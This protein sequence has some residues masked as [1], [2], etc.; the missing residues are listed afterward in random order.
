MKEFNKM[1]YGRYN[2]NTLPEI[3]FKDPN[4][5]FDE[6]ES[7]SFRIESDELQKEA[8]DIFILAKSINIPN[9][10]YQIQEVVYLFLPSN[11]RLAFI[12]FLDPYNLVTNLSRDLLFE[13]TKY[14]DLSILHG[15]GNYNKTCIVKLLSYVK[16]YV[17][18]SKLYNPSRQDCDEFFDNEDNFTPNNKKQVSERPSEDFEFA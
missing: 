3:L 5:F 4:W 14:I 16:Q 11:E 8:D 13:R 7:N 12:D 15:L 1:K 2:G 18:G 17:W 10:E 6:F 9:D